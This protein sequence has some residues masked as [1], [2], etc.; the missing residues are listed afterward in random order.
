[1]KK[2]IIFKKAINKISTQSLMI[3]QQKTVFVP[4]EILKLI[5]EV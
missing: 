3:T 5:P 4:L 1:M 2:A